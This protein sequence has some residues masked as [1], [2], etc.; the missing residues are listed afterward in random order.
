MGKLCSSSKTAKINLP[1]Q[2]IIANNAIRNPSQANDKAVPIVGEDRLNPQNS[3]AKIGS[4]D[5]RL[6]QNEIMNTSKLGVKDRSN[7]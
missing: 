6:N 1:P 7:S 5:T 3:F 2:N 4:N